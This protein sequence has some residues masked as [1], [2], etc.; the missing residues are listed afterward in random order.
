M[1][2][3]GFQ[4]DQCYLL[5]TA[6]AA[7]VRHLSVKTHDRDPSVDNK[8]NEYKGQG[9]GNTDKTLNEEEKHKIIFL[10]TKMKSMM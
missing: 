8:C 6:L 4:T 1:I 5:S 3:S 7:K 9:R 10:T 2:A